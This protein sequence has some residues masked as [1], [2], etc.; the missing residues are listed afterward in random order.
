MNPQLQRLQ[1]LEAGQPRSARWRSEAALSPHTQIIVA[2]DT[3][4]ADAAYRLAAE[5]N[6]EIREFDCSVFNG[7]Y[8]TGD[9]DTAYLERLHAARND[10]SKARHEAAA[11]AGDSALVGLHNHAT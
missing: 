7:D 10:D 11:R 8:V 5:G 1:W 3:L 4:K 9:V 6:P 2:D